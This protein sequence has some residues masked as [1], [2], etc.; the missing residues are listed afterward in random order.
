MKGKLLGLVLVGLLLV[1]AGCGGGDSNDVIV[2]E[3]LSDE[4]V[5]GYIR[6][7][8]NTGT[9]EVVP[10]ASRLFA[11]LDPLVNDEYRAFISFP[12]TVPF[13]AR[14]DSAELEIFINEVSSQSL[15]VPMRLELISFRNQTLQAIDYDSSPKLDVFITFPV[16]QSDRGRYVSI[17]VTPFMRQV[18]DLRLTNFQIR[19]LQ[20]FVSAEPGRIEIDD[21]S[22]D[23]APLLRVTYF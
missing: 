18:R 2:S 12:N 19:V 17:D 3:T 1:M 15:S 20:D 16:L 4:T 7:N 14:I 23:T 21:N 8:L 11:G 10:A 6:E 13:N 22:M 5:D 9:L